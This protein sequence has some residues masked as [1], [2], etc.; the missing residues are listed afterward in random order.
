MSDEWL[1]QRGRGKQ[2][3]VRHL[4][5]LKVTI[6]LPASPGTLSEDLNVTALSFT[7]TLTL[8]RPFYF[9]KQLQLLLANVL[10]SLF[11]ISLSKQSYQL[12]TIDYQ[13]STIYKCIQDLLINKIR[14]RCSCSINAQAFIKFTLTDIKLRNFTVAII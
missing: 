1:F 14:C 9:V 6:H 11:A 4:S 7:N 8:F 10:I 5:L 3:P 2:V 13:P 12:S